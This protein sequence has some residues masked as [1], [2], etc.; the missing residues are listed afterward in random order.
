MLGQP[1]SLP[2]PPPQRHQQQPSYTRSIDGNTQGR[3]KED[4]ETKRIPHQHPATT[5]QTSNS[6]N[7]K[8]VTYYSYLR[9]DQSG[10]AIMDMLKA[11]S[12]AFER[13]AVYGGACGNSSHRS[14][15][16][17]VLRGS[18]MDRIL[19][20]PTPSNCPRTNNQTHAI[21]HSSF[22]EKNSQERMKST[23]WKSHV[24]SHLRWDSDEPGRQTNST[25]TIVVHIRRRDVTPCCYP[26]WYVPNSYFEAMIE[27][28]STT[29]EYG[30]AD[31][32]NSSSSTL[33]RNNNNNNNNNNNKAKNVTVHIYSQSD[34]FES[35]T[36]FQMYNMHL[37]G[38]VGDVWKAIL[39]ADIFIGSKSE[40]SKVPAM[41][42]RAQVVSEFESWPLFQNESTKIF[43]NCTESMI[44]SC[45]NKWWLRKKKTK[46]GVSFSSSSSS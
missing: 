34:S 19:P 30:T 42:T 46:T 29:E 17:S 26:F 37:D 4:T 41:F 2:L 16:Q 38:D 12:F 9:K 33:I 40:F 20:I 36:P 8:K 6:P 13:G 3:S 23:E 22:Y 45:K 1:L 27:K 18:G 5:T 24:Q 44:Y 11:H 43:A 39:N 10:W 28:Y 15:V 14:D 21:Y 31:V 7:D 35:W 32:G 25:K